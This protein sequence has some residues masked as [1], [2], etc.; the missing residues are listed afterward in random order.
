MGHETGAFIGNLYGSLASEISHFFNNLLLKQA[1]IN[2]SR[3][4][5]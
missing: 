1:F 4:G 2:N 5:I 3:M